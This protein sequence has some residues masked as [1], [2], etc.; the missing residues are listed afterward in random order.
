M[1]EFQYL[2]VFYDLVVVVAH[3]FLNDFY[4]FSLATVVWTCLE[5]VMVMVVIIKDT[6]TYQSQQFTID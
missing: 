3:P 6:N 2:E 5:V 4:K 1:I